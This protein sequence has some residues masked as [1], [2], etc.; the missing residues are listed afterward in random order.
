MQN[1]KEGRQVKRENEEE[2]ENKRERKKKETQG[3]REIAREGAQKCKFA[4]ISLAGRSLFKFKLL[5]KRTS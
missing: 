5:I 1:K 3:G 2:G 4:P